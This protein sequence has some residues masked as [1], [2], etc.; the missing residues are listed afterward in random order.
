MNLLHWKYAV[1]IAKC[2]SMNKAA[3]KLYMDPPNLS[4]AMKALEASIGVTI[5]DRSAKGMVLTPDG[6]VFIRHAEKIVRQVEAVERLFHQGPVSREKFSISVPRA[7]YIANAFVTFSQKLPKESMTALYY[8]ETN[9]M[10]AIKN[11]LDE[12]YK[13][14][15]IRYAAVYDKYYKTMLDEKG[16]TYE[17]VAKF[18]HVLTMHKDH[19]LAQKASVSPKD[20]VPYAEV[21]FDDPFIQTLPFAEVKKAELLETANRSI[22]VFD[23]ASRFALLAENHETFMWTAPIP[24]KDLKHY[25]LIQI[26]CGKEKRRY[27]DVL[28]RRKDYKLS[29]LDHMF[30]SE[31]CDAKRKTFAEEGRA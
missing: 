24:E 26:E 22:Y 17:L 14:G 2:G 20:L 29:R 28:I 1:E 4:R 18:H 30:I 10:Q 27:K 7:S 6:E 15:I 5:F 23:R 11:I 25:G 3:E 8:K 9:A 16:L 19:P 21:A 13:L 12:G 31:L